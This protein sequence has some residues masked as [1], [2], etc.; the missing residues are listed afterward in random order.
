MHDYSG[1]YAEPAVISPHFD[2]P[3]TLQGGGR[4]AERKKTLLL[5]RASF[6]WRDESF[7]CHTTV[8]RQL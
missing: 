4:D 7:T 3:L 5:C 6:P 8:C 2:K 1:G